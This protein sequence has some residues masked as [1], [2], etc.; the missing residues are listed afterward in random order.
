M[1]AYDSLGIIDGLTSIQ[2]TFG[3][4]ETMDR[5]VAEINANR[6]KVFARIDHTVGAAQVGLTLRLTELIIF[7]NARGGTSRLAQRVRSWRGSALSERNQR[8][9]SAGDARRTPHPGFLG[10]LRLPN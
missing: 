4:K 1:R 9:L 7:G 6:M 2:S 3:P 5:L 10:H 8:N